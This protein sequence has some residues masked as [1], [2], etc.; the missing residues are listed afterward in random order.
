MGTCCTPSC[1]GK[2]CGG[3]GC[4]GD[5]GKCPCPDC[6][7]DE[8]WCGTG[9]VCVAG[10]KGACQALAKCGWQCD[11][12]D[13]EC[14][15]ACLAA[16]P[17]EAISAYEAWTACLEDAGYSECWD[18]QCVLD[19][20]EGCLPVQWEC[21]QGEASCLEVAECTF[22]CT[23]EE[24]CLDECLGSG[25]LGAMQAWWPFL[26]CA[27]MGSCA[28]GFDSYCLGQAKGDCQAE[29]EACYATCTPACG[30]QECGDDGCGGVCGECE[31]GQACK[32]G[33]CED[34]CVPQCA[35]KDCGNDGCDGSC[36]TCPEG[37][38]CI[39]GKCTCVPECEGRECGDDTC[40]GSCGECEKGFECDGS[41]L[42]GPICV[43][44][45]EGK[46]CGGDGCGGSCGECPE[47]QT[48]DDS[49]LCF[50]PSDDPVLSDIVVPD[51]ATSSD[52]GVEAPVAA[53]EEET[54]GGGSDGCGTAPG[55]SGP[56][57]WLLLLAAG[58]ILTGLRRA[59]TS[60][61]PG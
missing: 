21:I 4:G 43:T 50:E 13:Y 30:D 57:G 18:F 7:A 24:Y 55:S 6:E 54:A 49:G 25:S 40:G 1:D 23:D 56:A 48:C 2:E 5:C 9:G 53:V 41:G 3:D 17:P 37:E 60:S 34:L 22:A 15:D 47:G 33:K 11:A 46:Q 45:C 28:D 58:L 26:E 16:A 10:D 59:T 19:V 42:C 61:R 27:A 32:A 38:Q 12:Y 52:A 44:S 14:W 29:L 35:G 20:Y 51:G 36:G 31:K 8:T 39:G